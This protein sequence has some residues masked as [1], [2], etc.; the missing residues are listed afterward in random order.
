[1][2]FEL[3]ICLYIAIGIVFSVAFCFANNESYSGFY[4]FCI[5]IWPMMLAILIIV[6]IISLLVL[7]GKWIGETIYNII[8][9]F[10]Y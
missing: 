4:F 7:I 8:N 9:F 3:A 10:G 2:G 5:I 6:G 1:M